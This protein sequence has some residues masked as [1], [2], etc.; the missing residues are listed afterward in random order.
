V[1]E[2]VGKMDDVTHFITLSRTFRAPRERVFAA[3]TDPETMQ[4]W[5]VRGKCTAAEV[6][7]RVGGAYR[8]TAEMPYGPAVAFGTYREIVEPERLVFTFSW[9]QIPIGETVV[10]IDFLDRD[11]DCEMLFTQNLFPDE[12]TASIHEMTWPLDFDLLDK[13]LA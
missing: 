3:W 8:L 5:M 11:G 6:D 7:L 2:K 1:R 4:R 13:I 12:Q 9:E 10:T